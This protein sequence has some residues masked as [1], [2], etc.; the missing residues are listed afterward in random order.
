MLVDIRTNEHYDNEE[1]YHFICSQLKSECKAHSFRLKSSHIDPN[2]P[3]VKKCV[4]MGMKPFG[5]PTLSD[6]TL[7][8]FPSFKLGPGESSRSHSADEFIRISEI[9]NAIGQYTELL[10]G[11]ILSNT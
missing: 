1:V 3:L 11:I 4:A 8:P 9:R 2:H 10:D 5:S 7:M 6:Q